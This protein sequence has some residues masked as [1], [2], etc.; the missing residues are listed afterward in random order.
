[1]VV[2]V[3]R[4]FFGSHRKVVRVGNLYEKVNGADPA[5]IK[6]AVK[7]FAHYVGPQTIGMYLSIP[8]RDIL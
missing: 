3:A 8:S 7:N 4:N 5:N 6:N 2:S 1:M